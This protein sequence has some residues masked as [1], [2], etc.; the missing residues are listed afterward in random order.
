M[1]ICGISLDVLIKLKSINQAIQKG[2]LE[3]NQNKQNNKY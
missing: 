3:Q 2:V 1:Y